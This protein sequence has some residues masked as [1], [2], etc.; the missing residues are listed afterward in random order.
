MKKINHT[1][2]LISFALFIFATFMGC[3]QNENNPVENNPISPT[4]INAPPTLGDAQLHFQIVFPDRWR[5]PAPAILATGQA[6]PTVTIKVVLYNIASSSTTV[7]SKTVEADSNGIAVATFPD[8][9]PFQ[10]SENSPFSA[11]TSAERP[12]FPAVSTSPVGK[13]QWFSAPT[14]A[15][16]RP[17]S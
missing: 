10:R 16:Q 11:A 14:A 12:V 15:M 1:Y 6:T 3:A 8:L 13:M 9:P 5:K 2:V 7:L 4:I 17:R